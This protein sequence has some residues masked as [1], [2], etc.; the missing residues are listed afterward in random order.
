MEQGAPLHT[1]APLYT[2]PAPPPA[3]DVRL[4]GRAVPRA[5]GLERVAWAVVAAGALVVLFLAMRLAPDPRGVG[6]HEQLGLPPCGLVATFGVP[7]PSCGFTTTFTLAAHGRLLRAFIN[8]PFGLLL[9]VGTV[10]AVPIGVVG[11][12]KGVS[13][14]LLMDR[15]PL[16]RIVLVTFLLWGAAWGYKCWIVAHH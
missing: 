12:T 10:L 15:L 7:C 13:W 4:F 5:A 1:S 9:F 16:G 3:R 8:Q 14:L 11:A 6:T 2:P